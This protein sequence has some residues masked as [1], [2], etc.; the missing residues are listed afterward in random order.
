MDLKCR[1]IKCQS[2]GKASYKCVLFTKTHTG[3]NNNKKKKCDSV[4]AILYHKYD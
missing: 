1:S 2:S 4:W 3:M